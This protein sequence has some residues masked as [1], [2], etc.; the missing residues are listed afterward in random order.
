MKIISVL[1]GI[2]IFS[3]AI[4]KFF[5]SIGIEC[6]RKFKYI[7]WLIYCIIEAVIINISIIAML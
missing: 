7:K 2:I 3:M 1:I 4:F 6:D 5:L